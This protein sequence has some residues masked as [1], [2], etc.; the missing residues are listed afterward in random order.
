MDKQ[1]VRHPAIQIVLETHRQH[2]PIHTEGVQDLLTH[3]PIAGETPQ[4]PTGTVMAKASVLRQATPIRLELPLP[5]K[6]VVIR[7]LLSG[8]GKWGY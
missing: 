4:Q 6:I 3:I 8:R 7:I 1:S 2:T 5:N